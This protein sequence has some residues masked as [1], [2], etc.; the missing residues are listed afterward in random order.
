MT[1]YI[2]SPFCY[3]GNKYKQLP[4]LM[5]IFPEKSN[6]FIDLFTGGG[7]VAI[8]MFSRAEHIFANDINSFSIDIMKVFKEQDINDILTFI[9]K[10]IKEFKLTK[11][12]KEGYMKYRSLYNERGS[13]YSPLDLFT[14]A[15]YSFNNNMRFNNNGEMNSA[16]GAN[17]SSFNP[18]Q[19]NNT[20][21]LWKA[22]QN[23][24]ITN[25]DFRDFPI[26]NLNESDFIYCDPPYL[27][28]DAYYNNGADKSNQRLTYED[29]KAL[30]DF[31]DSCKAKWAMSNVLMHRGNKNEPL[32]EWANK[33]YT[34]NI[35]SD[36]SH[37][38]ACADLSREKTDKTIEVVITNYKKE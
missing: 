15:R 1:K 18:N 20:I 37:C 13:Y 6:N 36:Y 29:D 14:L 4:Q 26:N 31:L 33:Y 2:K 30:F 25:L 21:L 12:N 23:I 5:Q 22:L 11:T 19:R 3:V 32:I 16:F 9:D 8:N 35:K 24:T 17:R 27:I 7:D 10:R 28:T 38:V 34:Y